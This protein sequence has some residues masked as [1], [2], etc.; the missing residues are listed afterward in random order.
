M[1]RLRP[2]ILV[3]LLAVMVQIS[4]ANGSK[5]YAA[6]SNGDHDDYFRI[7]EYV[8]VLGKGWTPNSNVGYFIISPDLVE[9]DVNKGVDNLIECYLNLTC[10]PKLHVLADGVVT[11]DEG[12]DVSLTNTSWQLP[13][14]PE[15]EYR[16]LAWNLN[17][18]SERSNDSFY[19]A[20]S[21]PEFPVILIPAGMVIGFL[22]W[23]RRDG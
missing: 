19:P 20:P 2:V 22:L 8:Y 5:L 21:I 17:D 9:K 12:G 18:P 13:P 10:R 3:L 4:A 15:Q 16:L 14:N 7:G 23:K 11:A 6:D 1:K